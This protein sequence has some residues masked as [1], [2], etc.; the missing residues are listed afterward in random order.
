MSELRGCALLLP[1]NCY[2][3]VNCLGTSCL[4]Q[5][6]DVVDTDGVGLRGVSEETGTPAADE[7]LGFVIKGLQRC[8]NSLVDRDRVSGNGAQCI[9]QEFSL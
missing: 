3:H 8:H 2:I 7:Q 4:S 9:D 5:N 6:A 1:V